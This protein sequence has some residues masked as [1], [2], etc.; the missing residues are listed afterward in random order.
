MSTLHCLE[1]FCTTKRVAIM[2]LKDSEAIFRKG[3]GNTKMGTFGYAETQHRRRCRNVCELLW[4][5]SNCYFTLSHAHSKER[6]RQKRTFCGSSR[7]FLFFFLFS[8]WLTRCWKKILFGLVVCELAPSCE[9]SEQRNDFIFSAIAVN[10]RF[11]SLKSKLHCLLWTLPLPHSTHS[12]RH[13]FL[14]QSRDFCVE[15]RIF[16]L[17]F[18][19]LRWARAFWKVRHPG[20]IPEETPLPSD[21][22]RRSRPCG[23]RCSWR[24]PETTTT[25]VLKESVTVKL[26]LF[27]MGN[28]SKVLLTSRL[29]SVKVMLSLRLSCGLK[30]RA[31]AKRGRDILYTWPTSL[32]QMSPP[33][34]FARN[35]RL[36]QCW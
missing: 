13:F 14:F 27:F 1:K 36:L 26:C 23:R 4:M 29:F 11:N 16:S 3:R 28:R 34:L 25:Q 19:W 18:S 7:L 9:F 8:F 31:C 33:H 24:V 21:V 2:I 6:W 20:D 30:I 22:R 35:P 17:L 5:S 15:K 12:C 10:L 32:R